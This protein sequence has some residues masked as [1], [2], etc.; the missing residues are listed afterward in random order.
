MWNQ[1]ALALSTALGQPV[2]LGS[3]R[4]V[5]GGS[6]NNACRVESSAGPFFVKLNRAGRLGMFEAEADGL[7]AL[8]RVIRAPRAICHGVAGEHAF[9][10]LEWLDLVRQGDDAALG[11]ALAAMHRSTASRYGWERDNTIGSTAQHNEWMDDWIA[12]WRERRLGEQFRL[13]RQNG[14]R[15]AQADRLLGMLPSFFN[16]YLP[17]PSLLHGDLW[18][19]NVGFLAS[20]APVLFDPACYYGDREADLAMTELFGGFGRRFYD[21]YRAAWPLDSGYALRRDL[22]NLY[23]VLNHFNLFGG[24]YADE[25]ERLTERLLAAV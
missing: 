10:V 9:L 24:G 8:G 21:A 18:S 6:I 14:Q 16:G 4:A 5:G 7:D 22:Y 19:G 11:E 17:A 25:A 2:T 1:I 13:A 23:H 3:P 15:F 12:F 20:G